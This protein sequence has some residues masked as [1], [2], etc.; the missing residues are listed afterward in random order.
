MDRVTGER[1]VVEKFA[2]VYSTLYSS[3][4]SEEGMTELQKKIHQLLE[5]EYIQAKVENVPAEMGD[6]LHTDML[7]F[8]YKKN[9]STSTAT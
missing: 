3:A 1:H 9:C 6:K 2:E 4:S 5:I 7:Q 8:G